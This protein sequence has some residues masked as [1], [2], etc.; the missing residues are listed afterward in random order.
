MLPPRR[1]CVFLV[2][3]CRNL[4]KQN[5]SNLFTE[6]IA[7]LRYHD[8]E[9]WSCLHSPQP[10]R[11]FGSSKFAWKNR[12]GD[13]G[14]DADANLSEQFGFAQIFYTESVRGRGRRH[15]WDNWSCILISTCYCGR[16]SQSCKLPHIW[17]I[18]RMFL[19]FSS[20][21][22][23]WSSIHKLSVQQNLNRFSVGIARRIAYDGWKDNF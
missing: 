3:I 15:S 17:D 5:C 18:Q 16:R 1:V 11:T 2:W 20:Y 10:W 23:G 4:R 22:A 7:N 12:G 6:K 14:R 8:R 21:V 19:R 13:S 9:I